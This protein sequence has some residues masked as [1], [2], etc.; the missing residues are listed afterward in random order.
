MWLLFIL[1][2]NSLLCKYLNV[3]VESKMG[4]I[5]SS[6]RRMNERAVVRLLLR[7]GVASRAELA[8]AAGMSQPT[9]GKIT[10]DLIDRGILQELDSP[11][12]SSDNGRNGAGKIGRPGRML[13]LDS[14]NP[15]FLAIHLGVTETR[16]APLSVSVALT[17]RWPIIFPTPPSP[18]AWLG[19]LKDAAQKLPRKAYDGILISVPGVVDEASC[20]VLFSPNLHWTE[21]ARLAAMIQSVWKSPVIMTQEIRSLALG[22]QAAEPEGED[23]MLV[24]FGQGV[25]GAIMQGGKLLR[26]PLPLNGEIGHTP[27]AGNHRRCGCGA[28]GCLETLVSR[29]GLEASYAS[30]CYPETPGWDSL[31]GAIKTQGI[32]PWLSDT[33]NAT[34]IVI[35]G[36]LNVLGLRRVILTGSLTELPEEVVQYLE[37]RIRAGSMWARFGEVICESAPRRRQAGLAGVGIDRLLAVP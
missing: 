1:I 28:E 37:E 5:P 13:Q 17:D 7:M 18:E 29:H 8:K 4:A 16:F 25:G 3:M 14:R 30:A 34:A 26:N 10:Q 12:A 21:K 35:A 36:A 23:F 2:S 20:Q 11:S 22:H 19:L 15:R 9:V 6:L 24:D 31:A 32:M 33:L 27:V